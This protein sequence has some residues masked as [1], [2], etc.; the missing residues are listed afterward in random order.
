MDFFMIHP[1][2]NRP[3]RP[4]LFD[5]QGEVVEL[6]SAWL[7]SLVESPRNYSPKS[8]ELYGH[9]LKYFCEHLRSSELLS[10]IPIDVL[11]TS[12]STLGLEKYFKSLQSDG[13][14]DST[15]RNREVSLKEFFVWLTTAQAGHVRTDSGWSR[16]YM[17]RRPRRKMPRFITKNQFIQL[18][19]ALNHESQRCVLHFMYETGVRVSEVPRIMKHDIDLLQCFDE[20]FEYLPLLI[21]GSKGSGKDHIKERY[22]LISRAVF[23]RIQRYHNTAVYR[24]SGGNAVKSAFLNVKKKPLTA[25]AVQKMISD[26]R[27]RA[28]FPAGIIS[29]HRLRHGTALSILQGE[30]GND[31]IEKMV[32]IQTQFGHS[33]IRSTE[34][35]THLPAAM[36]AKLKDRG[37][38]SRFE[39]A[40]DIYTK[41]YLPIRLCVE[42]RGRPKKR[43]AQS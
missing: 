5:D 38:K 20:T 41:T 12:I 2:R 36:F 30:W 1:S 33:S 25:K 22:T 31:Y 35:Y 6:A 42:R 29:P 13:F 8:I 23:S 15:V 40:Q 9:N 19:C 11:L 16:R 14:A 24:F 7:R 17:T 32:L 39:E 21:R 4:T 34:Q 3:S 18:A 27:K 26:A 37:L 43:R 10:R 28:G